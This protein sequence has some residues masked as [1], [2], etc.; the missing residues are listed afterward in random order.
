MKLSNV[1]MKFQIYYLTFLTKIMT[2]QNYI[3]PLL[4]LEIRNNA[5]TLHEENAVGKDDLRNVTIKN[6][7]ANAFAFSLDKPVIFQENTKE[8][9]ANNEFL[10]EAPNIKKRCDGV[11]VCEEDGVTYIL[12]CELKSVIL[13]PQDY[14]YQLVNVHIF[15]EYVLNLYQ[16]FTQNPTL[17]TK[18][19]HFLFHKKDLQTT[20]EKEFRKHN[21]VNMPTFPVHNQDQMH[22]FPPYKVAIFP[23]EKTHFNHLKW[24]DLRTL[25]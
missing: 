1:L 8:R 21:I 19:E 9:K 20:Q 13:T 6:L 18:I 17:N 16:N 7:P 12:I 2:L 22:N 11:I 23:L 5:I 15:V 3:N 14:E 24:E 25:F 10:G 4:F